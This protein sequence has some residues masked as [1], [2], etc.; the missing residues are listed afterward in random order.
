M[1]FLWEFGSAGLCLP[2]SDSTGHTLFCSPAIVSGSSP[3]FELS[4]SLTAAQVG[5]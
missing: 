4:G 5:E 3:D 1:L 2:L